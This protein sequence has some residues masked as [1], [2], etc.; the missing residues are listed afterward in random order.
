[1]RDVIP[2]YQLFKP[3]E[4]WVV[5]TRHSGHLLNAPGWLR[6]GYSQRPTDGTEATPEEWD[7]LLGQGEV[8]KCCMIASASY[9]AALQEAVTSVNKAQSVAGQLIGTSCAKCFG[10][11]PGHATGAGDICCCPPTSSTCRHTS[12]ASA[13]GNAG[14]CIDCGQ[15]FPDFFAPSKK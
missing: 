11:L 1:M 2:T 12:I 5:A 14:L 4:G 7:S 8:I 15:E 3:G 10:Y 6:I 9:V 13:A